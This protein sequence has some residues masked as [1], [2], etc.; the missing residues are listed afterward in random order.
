MIFMC[1]LRDFGAGQKKRRAAPSEASPLPSAQK[2]RKGWEKE[3]GKMLSK[4]HLWFWISME[5]GEP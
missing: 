5:G 4:A 2:L 1:L 3:G